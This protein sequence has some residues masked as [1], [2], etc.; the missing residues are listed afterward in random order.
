M[1]CRLISMI[2]I[3]AG[4]AAGCDLHAQQHLIT[5]TDLCSDGAQSTNIGLADSDPS[6]MYAIYRDGQFLA[7]RTINDSK[8]PNPL[9][10]GAFSETGKYTIVEFSNDNAD[11]RHPEKGR[12]IQGAISIYKKPV[13]EV[14]QKVEIKSGELFTFQPVADI[15]GCSFRWTARLK[16]GKAAGFKK[17]GEGMVS[18]SIVLHDSNP[19]SMSYLITPYSPEHLGTCTGNTVEMTV[20]IIP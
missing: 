9:D 18:D 10:F 4:Y 8:S 5:G 11:F 19:V 6:K 14:P 2:L 7:V 13:M 15:R 16:S 1:I 20:W 17:S 3:I 12:T